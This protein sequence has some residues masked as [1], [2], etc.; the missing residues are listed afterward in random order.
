MHLVSIYWVGFGFSNEVHGG[1]DLLCT[2]KFHWLPLNYKAAHRCS[3][4]L[5]GLGAGQQ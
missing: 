1:V 3:F 2:L 4:W 5:H